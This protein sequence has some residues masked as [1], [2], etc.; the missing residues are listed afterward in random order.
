[1]A[2]EIFFIAGLFADEEYFSSTRAF[3]EDGLRAT[4]PEVTSFAIGSR[5]AKS[6]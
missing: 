1:L 5:V 2:A 3:A 4:L 6:F